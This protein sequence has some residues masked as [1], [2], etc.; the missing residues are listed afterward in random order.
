M[1]NYSTRYN[2]YLP[3]CKNM[4]GNSICVLFIAIIKI[5]VLDDSRIPYDVI[6]V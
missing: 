5:I 3:V 6:I 4:V 2:T 1:P